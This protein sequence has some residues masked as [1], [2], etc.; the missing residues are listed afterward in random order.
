MLCEIK[1]TKGGLFVGTCCL[2][3]CSTVVNTTH[4]PISEHVCICSHCAGDCWLLAAIASLT[5]DHQ[6]LARVVPPGQSF[7]EDY[8]GIFHFQV[9]GQDF[10]HLAPSTDHPVGFSFFLS[11]SFLLTRQTTDWWVISMKTCT[12]QS[13]IP[14]NRFGGKCTDPS[15]AMFHSVTFEPQLILID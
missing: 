5:L 13:K 1:I 12:L 4:C 8:A 11:L 15:S 10:S 14:K 9:R 2:Q 6:I 3:H 7:T